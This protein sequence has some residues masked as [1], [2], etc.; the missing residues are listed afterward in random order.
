M[1]IDRKAART[2][3]AQAQQLMDDAVRLVQSKANLIISI[4]L[5]SNQ[6]AISKTMGK[7]Q[8][9]PI[10]VLKDATDQRLPV[11]VLIRAGFTNIY[12]VHRTT[13][14]DLAKIKGVSLSS[15]AEIHAIT[16]KILKA[17]ETSTSTHIDIDNPSDA[18]FSLINQMVKLKALNDATKGSLK[19]FSVIAGL[20][21]QDLNRTK[22]L[23]NRL[24]WVTT[25]SHKQAVALQSANRLAEQLTDPLTQ[26]IASELPPLLAITYGDR[27][28]DSELLSEF[29]NN[30]SDYYALL[31]SLSDK[32]DTSKAL[33]VLNRE[34]VDRIEQQPFDSSLLKATLRKYQVFGIKFTLAQGR[35]ILGDEMGL[36]KTIQALGV[37]AQRHKDGASHFVIVCPASVLVNWTREIQTRTDLPVHKI[38]G[39]NKHITFKDWV[40]TGGIA[41]TTFDNLKSIS[42][43]SEEIRYLNIDTLIVDEAHFAKNQDS[44]RAKEVS[45]WS[46][47]I[48]RV[49]FLTGTP[50]ENRV[51]EFLNLANMI[52]RKIL[53]KLDK[54][55]LAAGPEPF[56]QAVA[57]IYLRRNAREVLSELPPLVE[58]EEFCEWDDISETAYYKA[59]ESGNFM[60][61]RRAAFAS[62]DGSIPEKLNRLVELVDEAFENNQSVIVFSY[63]RDVLKLVHQILGDK[64][65]EP[66]TGD[67]PP[68]ARQALVDDFNQSPEPRVLIGQIMAAGTG[69]NV[70]RASVIILCE[71]QIKPTLETQAI[72]RAHRMGQLRAVQV[73]RLI[74]SDGVDI[75]MQ[76]M[77]AGKSAEFDA[78]AR[79]S[80]LAES[81]PMAKEVSE[82]SVAKAIIII[83][84]ARL[85]I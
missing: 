62:E 30:S 25:S 23:L 61:M 85:G 36:G 77:L 67:L 49:M 8:T 18:E 51:S 32:P 22:P 84:R 78:Y 40:A 15:A 38:H 56:Q 44:G 60:A 39:P 24:K 35:V 28:S 63:F 27:Q 5:T 48:N 54:A 81:T 11:E 2:T 13:N 10:D 53:S 16:G 42:L 75:R 26:S 79:N 50:M 43:T 69:L 46:N 12:K 45:K 7:L 19:E 73:H 82:E 29:A 58:V 83:E 20:L 64:A 4:G 66:I 41:L 71:P 17:V 21:R 65:Y 68:S 31:D 52:D 80:A 34:L 37:L 76:E 3:V 74:T 14:E 59:V 57:P 33:R 6:I 1:L 70:Q 55:V 47:A 72:A 9:I